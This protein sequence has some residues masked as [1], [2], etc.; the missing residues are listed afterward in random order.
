MDKKHEYDWLVEAFKLNSQLYV[1]C[2]NSKEV[3]EKLKKHL[4]DLKDLK[5]SIDSLIDD[6]E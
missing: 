3:A 6:I 4:F 1:G 2:D 5:D